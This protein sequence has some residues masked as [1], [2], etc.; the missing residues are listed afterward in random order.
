[1][2]RLWR[3]L[4]CAMLVSIT[5][6]ALASGWTLDAAT[7]AR[8]RSGPAV[9]TMPPLPAVVDAWSNRPGDRIVI[10]YPGGEG[11]E[12]WAAELRDWLVALGLPGQRID[13][14]G[15]GEPDQLTIAIR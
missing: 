4:A 8:P 12:V 3:P 9:L 10:R 7:W 13:L 1:M 2:Q 6:P 5:A 15:G 14:A 11:G